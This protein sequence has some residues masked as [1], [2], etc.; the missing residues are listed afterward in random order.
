[1][2]TRY[3]KPGI[4]D[5][6]SMENVTIPDA[7]VMYYRLIV[8]V[9]DF[10]RCDARPLVL[11]S[12]CF[13]IRLYATADK[14]IEWAKH[15]ESAG[16]LELYEAEG[17]PYLQLT[18]W[19]NKPRAPKSRFPANAHTCIHPFTNLPV[20]V[21]VT[22]K[23]EPELQATSTPLAEKLGRSTPVEMAKSLAAKHTGKRVP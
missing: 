23:P 18:K 20:T 15:L 7:E 1:M 17:K 3:L 5:S 8:S 22:T 11:K 6:Q 2:P 19:D 16:L 12:L 10:G 13:P 4:R 21:T 9:D 14:C